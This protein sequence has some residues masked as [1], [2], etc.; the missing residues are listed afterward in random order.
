MKRHV[1]F[2]GYDSTLQEEIREFLKD[3]DGDAQFSDTTDRSIRILSENPVDTVVLSMHSLGDAAILKYINQYY[4]DIR[5][6]ISANKEF[7]DIINVFNKG[8]F[9]LLKQPLKLE[10]LSDYV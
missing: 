8:R 3:R 5:V 6:L 2:I 9:G 1:L 10:D 4:P 7:D